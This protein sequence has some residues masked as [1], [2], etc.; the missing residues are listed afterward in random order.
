MLKSSKSELATLV[1]VAKSITRAP[2][3]RTMESISPQSLFIRAKIVA[4]LVLFLNSATAMLNTLELMVIR[5]MNVK[6][7]EEKSKN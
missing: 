7:K 4:L 1:L 5:S 3:T 2:L 6:L